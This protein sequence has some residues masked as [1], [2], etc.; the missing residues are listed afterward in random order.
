MGSATTGIAC[1]KNKRSFIGIELDEESYKIAKERSNRE[2]K[3]PLKR[4]LI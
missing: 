4:K 3:K 1:I 2:F